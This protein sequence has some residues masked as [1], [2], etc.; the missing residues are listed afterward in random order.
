MATSS[1]DSTVRVWDISNQKCVQTFDDIQSTTTGLEWSFNGSLLGILTKEKILNIF[2]PR[3]EGSV[4]KTTTH[5]GARPQKLAWLGNSQHIFT[6]GFSKTSER[7]YAVWDTRD[8]S[9]PLIKKRL[10]DYAGIPFPYFD[11][12]S[13]VLFIAGKGENAVSFFQFSTE[14]PNYVDFL[15]AYKGKE[16][17]KG[18]SFLPKRIV[19]V[20]QCEV[21]RGV[22]LTAKTVEY[23]QFKVPRKSGTF[24]A[25]LFPPCRSN[26]PAMKF[27]EYWTGVDKDPVRVEMRPDAQDH[28]QSPQRRSTFLAKLGDKSGQAQALAQEAEASSLRIQPVVSNSANEELKSEVESLTQKVEELSD[29]LNQSRKENQELQDRIN[30]LVSEIHQLKSELASNHGQ[31]Q[32]QQQEYQQYDDV[33]QQP[34]PEEGQYQQQEEGYDQQ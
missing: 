14:S 1:A 7:E 31:Q 23:V 20:M 32:N 25:D 8:L 29:H 33:Q 12:D 3:K 13:R 6:A 16:P 34:Q 4:L 18:F 10:D 11:E 21:A 24:Q 26:E 22:R 30:E 5:E 27:E 9:A 15:Y 17:Q 19:D 2:D 28:T